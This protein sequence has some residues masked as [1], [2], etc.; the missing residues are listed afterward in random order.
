LWRFAL[1]AAANTDPVRRRTSGGVHPEGEV[2]LGA[3]L[4]DRRLTLG[5][6]LTIENLIDVPIC[7]PVDL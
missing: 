2:V 5:Q 1:V 6:R 7:E 4:P 3:P